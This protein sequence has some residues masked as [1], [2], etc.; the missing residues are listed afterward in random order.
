MDGNTPQ[1]KNIGTIGN[2]QRLESVLLNH[3][4]AHVLFVA[5]AENCVEDVVQHQWRETGG[6]FIQEQRSP[7]LQ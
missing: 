3:Y 1:R 7:D 5:D 4:D 2:P 6:G